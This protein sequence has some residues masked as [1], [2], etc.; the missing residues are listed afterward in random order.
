MNKNLTLGTAFI[1]VALIFGLTDPVDILMPTQIQMT[2]MVLA[3]VAYGGFLG[4]LFKERPADEREEVLLNQSSRM[5]FLAGTAVLMTG[6]ILQTLNHTLDHW[7]I[8]ALGVMVVTKVLW[9]YRS[10]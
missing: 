10:D 9:L 1:F 2:L 4:L 7:L 5:A 6:I 3:V 8:W